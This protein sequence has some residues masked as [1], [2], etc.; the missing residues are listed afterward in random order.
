LFPGLFDARILLKLLKKPGDLLHGKDR[1]ILADVFIPYV[2]TG[3][4][5]QTALHLPLKGG[6]DLTIG[7]TQFLQLNEREVDHNGRAADYG[8]SILR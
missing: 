5:A 4:L 8:D 7:K 6:N 3:A 1:A 2:A